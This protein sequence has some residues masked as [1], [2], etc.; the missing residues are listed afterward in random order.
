MNYFHRKE[1]PA[2]KEEKGGERRKKT[3][4]R[5]IAGNGMKR[6]RSLGMEERYSTRSEGEEAKMR[7]KVLK[8]KKLR[9]RKLESWRF[10]PLSAGTSGEVASSQGGVKSDRV[11]EEKAVA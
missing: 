6:R 7:R 1:E 11:P 9:G 8:E 2:I 4:A 5:P 10:L 3:K